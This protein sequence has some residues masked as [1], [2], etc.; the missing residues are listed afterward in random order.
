MHG[1]WIG[2]VGSDRGGEHWTPDGLSLLLRRLADWRLGFGGS[3]F[4]ALRPPCL[5][6]LF[7]VWG[8]GW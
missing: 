8:D 5:V 3:R 4:V 2:H 6:S 1:C 7:W